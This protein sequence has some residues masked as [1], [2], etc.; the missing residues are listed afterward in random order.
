MI[1]LVSTLSLKAYAKINLFLRVLGKRPDGYHEIDSIMTRISL[2]DSVSIERCPGKVTVR[3]PGHPAIDGPSNLAHRAALAYLGQSGDGGGVNILISKEIPLAAGLGGGSSDAAA[4][5][6]GLQRLSDRPL[7]PEKL[8]EIAV[9]L[10]AD[11]PFFLEEGPCRARGIGERLE[12]F[13]PLPDF[14]LLLAFAPFGLSTR[15]VYESLRF[16][17]TSPGFDARNVGPVRGT[18]F[19]QFVTWLHND[20][21][22]VCEVF[23]PVIRRVRMEL[24]Q[25]GAAGALMTGSGPTVF[26]LFE[27]EEEASEAKSRIPKETGW[28]Y[29]V[30]KGKPSGTRATE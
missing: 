27:S 2:A 7:S 16:P 30:V 25:A 8:H 12:P 23:R 28:S 3:C 13:E 21:Q 9:L 29:L 4:V 17:L 6:V 14:A 5:L 20:L 18:G 1:G 22:P 10:G 19:E 24:T 15:K 26:G 11:V